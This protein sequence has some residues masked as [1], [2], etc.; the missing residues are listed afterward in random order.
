MTD[1]RDPRL[2]SGPPLRARSA[3]CISEQPADL[4]RCNFLA[5][6]HFLRVSLEGLVATAPEAHAN[7]GEFLEDIHIFDGPLPRVTQ[8]ITKVPHLFLFFCD[9]LIAQR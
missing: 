2:V 9:E 4:C 1:D 7:K 5:E 6:L 3:F 8:S